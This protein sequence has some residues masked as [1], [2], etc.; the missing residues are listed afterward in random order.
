MM[1]RCEKL[2]AKADLGLFLHKAVH[3]GSSGSEEETCLQAGTRGFVDR[4]ESLKCTNRSAPA[5][6]TAIPLSV[7]EVCGKRAAKLS[8]VHALCAF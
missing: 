1:D 8:G 3:T 4:Y 7:S 2:D 6:L 5:Q